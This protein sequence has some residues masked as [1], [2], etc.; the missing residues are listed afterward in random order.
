MME[1]LY[2]NIQKSTDTYLHMLVCLLSCFSH[3]QLF[4]NLGTMV[5]QALLSMWFS[6]QEY[7]SELPSHSRASSQP[8]DGT[9]CLICLLH[10]QGF[11]FFFFY[12]LCHLGSP[13]LNIC[14]LLPQ[15]VLKKHKI[16]FCNLTVQ[17]QPHR[18]LTP[19]TM[20]ENYILREDQIPE[21]QKK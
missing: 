8:R 19:S 9:P 18:R 17:V 10:W 16:I 5:H 2:V 3:V 21:Q 11:F 13:H 14:I 4:A 15:P 12:H 20:L 7:W 6:R 1:F